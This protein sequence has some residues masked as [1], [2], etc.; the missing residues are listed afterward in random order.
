MIDCSVNKE[1]INVQVCNNKQ[2]A[3]ETPINLF[4]VSI[5]C[6]VMYRNNEVFFNQY[7]TGDV[8]YGVI[9]HNGKV[10]CMKF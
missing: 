6:C 9:E 5:F 4:P 8:K 3:R 10:E 1:V 2:F 7:I